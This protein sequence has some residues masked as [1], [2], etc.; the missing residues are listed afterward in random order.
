MHRLL[1]EKS[2][3]L[4]E[5]TVE[6]SLS[7]QLMSCRGPGFSEVSVVVVFNFNF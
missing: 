4:E 3:S 6:Q 7:F 5:R 2:I 1:Q